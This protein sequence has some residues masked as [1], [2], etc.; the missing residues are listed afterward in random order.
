MVGDILFFKKTNSWISRVIA[1]LTNGE[2]THVGLIVSYD[3]ETNIATIIE[4][5]RFIETRIA[6]V[7]IDDNYSIFSTGEKPDWQRDMIIKYAYDSLGTKYDYLHILGLAISLIFKRERYAFFN[8][9][10]RIICSEM[11]DLSYYKA[12]VNRI[13]DFNL[14]DITPQE[15]IQVYDLKEIRKGA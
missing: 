8:I 15:L 13:N 6:T 2:Y 11:I 14:G 1:K 10:N 9:K 7:V 4:S 3:E 5:N 12:D